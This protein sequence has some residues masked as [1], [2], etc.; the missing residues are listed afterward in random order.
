MKINQSW[1]TWTPKLYAWLSLLL[2]VVS[3]WW[4]DHSAAHAPFI[5]AI[6]VFSCLA[7]FGYSALKRVSNLQHAAQQAPR[8]RQSSYWLIMTAM[9]SATQQVL[10]FA[11][12]FYARAACWLGLQPVF[13]AILVGAAAVTLWT[14]WHR[15]ILEHSI[16]G[17]LFAAMALFAGLDIALPI[18]GFGHVLALW[19]AYVAAAMSAAGLMIWGTPKRIGHTLGA[20]G[21]MAAGGL[22]LQ[23]SIVRAAIPPAP[24]RLVRAAIGERVVALDLVGPTTHFNAAPPELACFTEVWAPRGVN[25]A[26]LHDWYKDGVLVDT[27]ALTLRGGAQAGFRTWSVKQHLGEHPEGSWRCLA[28]TASEQVLGAT[29]VQIGARKSTQGPGRYGLLEKGKW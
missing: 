6:S 22:V 20:I 29:E 9:Q 16:W 14:P 8:W 24:L 23:S 13:V 4:M 15:F 2:G 3:A 12:P 7:M 25:D 5:A 1:R 26:L 11:T 28:R 27:I 21:C 18:L 10:F 19:V 17:A